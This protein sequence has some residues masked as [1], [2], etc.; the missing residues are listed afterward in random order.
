MCVIISVQV[1]SALHLCHY[2]KETGGLGGCIV[3][4]VVLLVM[5]FVTVTKP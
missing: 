5:D 1:V 4:C 2:G 3:N